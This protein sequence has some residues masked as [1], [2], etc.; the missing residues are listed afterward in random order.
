MAAGGSLC[1]E[2]VAGPTSVTEECAEIAEEEDDDGT[3]SVGNV[4]KAIPVDV[5]EELVD[6]IS[7]TLVNGVEVVD[8]IEV[9]VVDVVLVVVVLEVVDL[10]GTTVVVVDGGSGAAVVSVSGTVEVGA[11]LAGTKLVSMLLVPVHI[12]PTGHCLIFVR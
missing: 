12:L 4:G 11:G 10:M 9:D 5:G 6:V 8:K 3:P 1:E 7:V 2:D